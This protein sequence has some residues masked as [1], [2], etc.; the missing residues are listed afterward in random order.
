MTGRA[1]IGEV[2]IKVWLKSIKKW[3]TTDKQVNAQKEKTSRIDTSSRNPTKMCARK[4]ERDICIKMFLMERSS[5]F[6]KMKVLWIT[7]LVATY[8]VLKCS[9]RQKFQG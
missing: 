7:E 1:Y 3:V 5:S 9:G 8:I 4:Q 6:L 2:L